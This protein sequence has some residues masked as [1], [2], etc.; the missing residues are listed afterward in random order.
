MDN[1]NSGLIRPFG[2]VFT[3]LHALLDGLVILLAL[4]LAV[5]ISGRQMEAG[6]FSLAAA[7]AFLLLSAYG[8]MAGLYASWR[9]HS[10]TSV[11]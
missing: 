6:V 11:I 7:W 2:T 9:T 8:N 10:F 1:L 5:L 3:A 4:H